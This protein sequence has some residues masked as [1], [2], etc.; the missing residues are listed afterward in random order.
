M[1]AGVLTLNERLSREMRR[2]QQAVAEIDAALIAYARQH[3]GRFIRYGSS[4]KG[5]MMLHS[6]IDIVADF[7]GGAA[8]PAASYAEDVCSERGMVADVR[9]VHHTSA[10]LFGRALAEGIVLS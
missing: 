2:M 7:D 4:A 3:G 10:A 5:R 1:T 9:A 6:D 8:G